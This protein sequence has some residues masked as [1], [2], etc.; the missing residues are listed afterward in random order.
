MLSAGGFRTRDATV[1]TL[2]HDEHEQLEHPSSHPRHDL[3]SHDDGHE[4]HSESPSTLRT[5][6]LIESLRRRNWW[7]INSE[8]DISFVCDLTCLCGCCC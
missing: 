7:A 1:T 4:E 8:R 5:S 3:P 6:L 2:S